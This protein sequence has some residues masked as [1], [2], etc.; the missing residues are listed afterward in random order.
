MNAHTQNFT[1][2][3]LAKHDALVAKIKQQ[4]GVDVVGEGGQIS[5][6]GV[7][8]GWVYNATSEVLTITVIHKPFYVSDDLAAK[9]INEL[10]NG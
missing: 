3:D 6:D 7:T 10:V 4:F 2:I 8:L 1:G 5:K 9:K